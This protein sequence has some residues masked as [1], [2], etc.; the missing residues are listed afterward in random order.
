VGG[1][2]A[3]GFRGFLMIS[4]FWGAREVWPPSC[5]MIVRKA[6]KSKLG[7]LTVAME[8]KVLAGKKTGPVVKGSTKSK[9]GTVKVAPKVITA[10]RIT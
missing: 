5:Y 6:A 9:L 4:V 7:E 1:N 10:M 8:K 3:R 2:K